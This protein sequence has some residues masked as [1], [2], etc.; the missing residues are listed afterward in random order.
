MK[1]SAKRILR[2]LPA[3]RRLK[4]LRSSRLPLPFAEDSFGVGG[5]NGTEIAEQ[6][7]YG[8]GNG[9]D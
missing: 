3:W 2:L 8:I 6:G 5:E 9:V 1:N 4:T 7:R